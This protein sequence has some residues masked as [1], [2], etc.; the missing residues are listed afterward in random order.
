MKKVIII[1][2][3]AIVVGI[4]AWFE[5]TEARESD[6]EDVKYHS[7]FSEYSTDIEEQPADPQRIL[8]LV[9][10]ERARIGVAP[11]EVDPRINASAQ[12]KADDMV[13]RNYRDH[14]SPEGIHGYELVFK[15]T[16]GE[17]RRASE[18]LTWR[19]DNS[20]DTSRDAFNSWMNSEPHRKALQNP[21]Y[22]KTGIGVKNGVVVQHFCELK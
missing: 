7:K 16:G 2:I 4:G 1:T 13:N 22:T 6:K 12:E 11:L 3:L 15:H 9:N 21:K 18:N 10:Q 17:C 5:Y 20:S 19:T 8:E 14:V